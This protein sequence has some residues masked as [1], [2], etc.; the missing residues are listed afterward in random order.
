MRSPYDAGEPPR[1]RVVHGHS[2][3][4]A[5]M[6]DDSLKA[7]IMRALADN[8]LV[9]PDEIAVAVLDGDVSLRGKV[10]S[11]VQRREAARTAR[12]VPGVRRVDDQ[13]ATR[14][15]SIEGRADADTEAA[16]L[17]A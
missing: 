14:H 17:D 3:E 15:L 1:R 13:L 9:H 10:G 2:D 16:V 11:P 7:A 6:S 8:G 4:S 5:V 12:S